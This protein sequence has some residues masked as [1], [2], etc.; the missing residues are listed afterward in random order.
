MTA[1]RRRAFLIALVLGLLAGCARAGV[2]LESV[3]KDYAATDPHVTPIGALPAVAGSCART[4]SADRCQAIAFLA[5]Q[6]LGVPFDQV[7]TIDVVPN[8]SP[9]GIDFAHRTFVAVELADGS[10]HQVVVSC[11]G[12]AGAF[13]PPC[14]SQ[15][16]VPLTFPRGPGGGGYTDTPED[17]TPFPALDSSAV[18][19]ARPLEMRKL[20]VQVTGVGPQA[21]VVGRA[22]L[23]NGY[24]A[25]GR[26]ELSDPWPSDVLFI[27][28]IRLELRSIA[29]G[30]QLQN[31][32][33][34]GWHAGVEEVE[35]TLT[36]DV[37]WFEPGAAFTIVDLVVQ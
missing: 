32:Y 30:P 34:H 9:D 36:F 28:G 11:P 16:T 7:A 33:E 12:V 26:F 24:L 35:A 31:L 29:G 14:M 13:D 15:P 5:S 8:P 20:V 23:P 18:K 19:L 1:Q 2:P 4:L 17:A 3:M 37:G 25:E 6:Q 22:L 21:I 10:R 27:G